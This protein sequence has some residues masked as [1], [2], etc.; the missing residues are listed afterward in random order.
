MIAD[1]R[2]VI[3][4]TGDSDASYPEKKNGGGTE[5]RDSLLDLFRRCLAAKY[6]HTT[7]DGDYCVETEGRTLYLLFEWSDGRI[8]WKNNLDFP[9]TP[10]KNQA[11][12]EKWYCHRGFLRAWK[13]IRD[14]VTDSVASEL[15]RH[16]ATR[17]IVAVGYSP[18]RGAFA[19]CNGGSG[20]SLR[21]AARPRIR[22]RVPARGV[23]ETA[24]Y[25]RKA[26]LYLHGDTQCP[27]PCNPRPAR[28]VRVPPRRQNHGDR[29]RERI[30]PHRRAYAGSIYPFPY[31]VAERDRGTAPRR[32][33]SRVP[34]GLHSRG[35]KL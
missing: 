14:E 26:L 24:G 35:S 15:L 20:L 12:G 18:R 1:S 25:G 8:D 7:G 4:V 6:I 28:A 34:G 2:N 9:A 11:R 16:P 32:G 22:L 31:P 13:G 21:G 27:R 10:Y 19:V 17:E 23:R 29:K 30:P 5:M 33:Q 3:R